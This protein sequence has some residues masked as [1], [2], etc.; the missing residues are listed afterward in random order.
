MGTWKHLPSPFLPSSILQK[1]PIG[2]ILRGQGD[3]G[4]AI[5]R[6]Q[7]PWKTE[8]RRKRQRMYLGKGGSRW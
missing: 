1:A 7:S 6:Y 3:L 8:Q 2:L 5:Y 4:D